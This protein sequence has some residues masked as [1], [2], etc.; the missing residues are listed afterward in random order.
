[1]STL[2]A[3]AE[4]KQ[5]PTATESE[6]LYEIVWHKWFSQ[7]YWNPDSSWKTLK[8][9][10]KYN[11]VFLHVWWIELDQKILNLFTK[12]IRDESR[13]TISRRVNILKITVMLQYCTTIERN[14]DVGIYRTNTVYQ[15]KK[16][17]VMTKQFKDI[18]VTN[19][20][21]WHKSEEAKLDHAL[22][23]QSYM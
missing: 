2:T 22:S 11:V 17:T 13:L 9:I 15:Q 10:N 1:M 16:S 4:Q 14:Q 20:Q 6:I 21:T 19:D 23:L 18:R 8:M 5:P 12:I 3:S 7:I